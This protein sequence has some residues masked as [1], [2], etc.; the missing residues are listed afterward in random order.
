[1]GAYYRG[2]LHPPPIKKNIFLQQCVLSPSKHNIIHN[3]ILEK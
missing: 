2:F 1:M 3:I